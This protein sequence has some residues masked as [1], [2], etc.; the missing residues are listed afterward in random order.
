[1]QCQEAAILPLREVELS[2]IPALA[3]VWVGDLP[4]YHR[5]VQGAEHAESSSADRSGVGRSA[6]AR[7]MATGV[8]SS[9]RAAGP[10]AAAI[11]SSSS[12]VHSLTVR[13]RS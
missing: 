11:L 9:W 1:V 2:L 7:F 10:S 12:L 13:P 3:F 6:A 8:R 5:Q 4:S